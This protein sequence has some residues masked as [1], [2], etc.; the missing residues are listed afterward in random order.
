MSKLEATLHPGV[1]IKAEVIPARMSVTAA[2]QLVGV[3]R[4]A[5]SNL[6]NGKSAVSPEM[7][8]RLEKAFGC[9]RSTLLEMQAAYDAS[10]AEKKIAPVAT[11]AYVPPF[12][13]IKANDIAAWADHNVT[14]RSRL[15]VLLRTLAHSTG[16]GLVQIDFPGNDDAERPG[17]D[18]FTQAA[19]AS[20]WIP[21]GRCGWE[22][23]VNEDVK[24]KADKDFRKSIKA[25]DASDQQNTV[26][27]FVS[28]RRWPGKNAWVIAAKARKLWKDVRAYD[29]SDL[30]Q[31]LEQSLPAQA[32]FANETQIAA[33]NV[34]SL[35]RCWT[36]WANVSTPPLNGELFTPAVEAAS[37]KILSRL[38]KA[39]DRPITIAADSTEEGLAFI[40]QLLRD[41]ADD[42]LNGF[43][44]RAIVFDKTG[45][46]PRLAEGVE[47]FIAIVYDRDVERELARYPGSMHSFVVYPRNGIDNP[48]VILEPIG[49]ETFRLALERMGKGRDEISR[50]SDESGHSLTVLRRR[51]SNVPAM[52]TPVWADDPRMS[53]SI[54]PFLLVGA[55]N[56]TNEADR[57]GLSRVAGGCPYDELE[58]DFQIIVQLNDAPVW[59]LGSSRS[60]VSKVDLLHAISGALTSADL[61][62]FF[63]L[64]VEVLGEDDPALDLAQD[65]RWAAAIHGKT[66][67][68]SGAFR[69]GISETLVLM[70]VY[71]DRIFGKRLGFHTEM[72]VARIVNSLLP[73]PLEPRRLE[74]NDQDLP[75]YAEAAPD[76]FLSI[77][78]RDLRTENPAVLHLLRPADAGP[79]SHPSRTGL[80]WA[81][82]GLAWNPDMLPRVVMILA[83]LAEVEI[84]DNWVNKPAHSL[85]SIFRSWMPQTAADLDTR[86]ALMRMLAD[87]FPGVAWKI[88]IAQFG[89][90]HQT[91]D[92]SHKPRWRPDGFGFG[93]PLRD[94]TLRAR[95]QLEMVELALS[96]KPQ[97]LRSLS[98]LVEKLHSLD[99]TLADRVWQ[100]VTVWAG[101]DAS[102]VERAAMRE[103]IRMTVLSRT[104]AVRARASG[105]VVAQSNQAQSAYAALE[106]RDLMNR[107]A[108]LFRNGY[109]DESADEVEELEHAD[110]QKRDERIRKM[111]V[112]AMRE[113]R[114]QLGVSALLELAGRSGTAGDIGFHAAHSLLSEHDLVE[115]LRLALRS[116]LDGSDPASASRA[117]IS[118]AI[119]A[120]PDGGDRNRVLRAIA[121]GLPEECTGLLLVLA[122]FGKTT[123][124][125]VD[126]LGEA[127]QAR[128]WADVRPNG[129][130]DSENEIIEGIERLLKARR[131]RAAFSWMRLRPDRLEARLLHRMLL[132]IATGGD[133]VPGDYMLEQ[134]NVDRAFKH[135]GSSPDLTLED[136][137]QA[138]Y[139][140]L[141]ALAR[142]WDKW[143]D[144]YGIPNLQIYI[145]AHPEVF[146]QAIAWLFRRKDGGD[147]PLEFQ[148][149]HDRAVSIAERS[150]K[151]LDALTRIPGYNEAGELRADRL[152]EW[153]TTVR[154]ATAT[155]GRAD[156]ADTYIGK[157]LAHSPMGQ[158]GVW[159]C[160]AVRQVMEDVQSDPM[161]GGVCV[162]VYNSRGVYMRGDSGDQE[163]SLADKYRT[164]EQAL[165]LSY[166]Y[167]SRNLLLKLVRNYEHEAG[168]ED[169]EAGI[170]RRLR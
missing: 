11:T 130:L 152:T 10:L 105:R 123:W 90:H 148:V 83:R 28:P 77:L 135:I 159:P 99:D 97:T 86:I 39:P 44:D 120:V 101:N 160:E 85:Q 167:V 125:M 27:I 40:A 145:Q 92:Y 136:K 143:S 4:P 53:A 168:R 100:L 80:L 122:P 42:N 21:D 17:W 96:W 3:G 170:R 158:D 55:W 169:I 155:L 115:F 81:L 162:G 113:I 6:L 29:A 144:S 102:D 72:E 121:A 52:R 45:V 62:R 126:E 25:I 146:V 132:A 30:E 76:E 5:L 56:S 116:A 41:R 134:Y 151:L 112:E 118:G 87:R 149:P 57:A 12:L 59:S 51:L 32:W 69:R 60:V 150:Y 124:M 161:M 89:S 111:R 78:E 33:G 49:Y 164:W 61:N 95:F 106:P 154:R 139:A 1:R 131:P 47:S 9:P 91:G 165:R 137:A 48:D 20:A 31:W 79:F 114:D 128:Y 37:R 129:L 98:D 38:S 65:Q 133:D 93:E 74:A 147:D 67:Q 109:V 66:R 68:F 19:V 71:G 117:L 127:E 50:L 43:R 14:A 103:K 163:R 34:R 110:F 54:V 153:I 70:A 2:A 107:H 88:C 63:S 16:Q 138:E 35:D 58:R 13:S 119:W 141:E 94:G 24:T 36:D 15:S 18:G 82:E 75:T 46:L 166:P 140:F 8:T 7:A 73:S 64:A 142:P 26:F 108:W 156:I 22:F 84:D 104:A 23:G 157:L